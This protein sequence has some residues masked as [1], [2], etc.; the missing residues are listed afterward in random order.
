M[1]D[2]DRVT[3]WLRR[4]LKKIWETIG[5]SEFHV[6]CSDNTKDKKRALTSW[7]VIRGF[8]PSIHEVNQSAL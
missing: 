7:K 5:E 3:L 4:K 6:K 8:Q 2:D 1:M